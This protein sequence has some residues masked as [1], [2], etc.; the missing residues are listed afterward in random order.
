MYR[1][2]R[3][4]QGL[5]NLIQGPLRYHRTNRSRGVLRNVTPGPALTARSIHRRR[6]TKAQG[7]DRAMWVSL[8]TF[9]TA[10]AVG[11]SLAAV[12]MQSSRQRTLRR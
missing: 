8:F 11:L 6:E 3:A 7:A 12:L 2:S 9:A 4:Q 5:R 1:E 10:A